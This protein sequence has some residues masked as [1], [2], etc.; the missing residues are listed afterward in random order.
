MYLRRRDEDIVRRESRIRK[1]PAAMSLSSTA[2]SLHVT[3]DKPSYAVT[4]QGVLILANNFPEKSCFYIYLKKSQSYN[5]KGFLHIT[6]LDYL[7]LFLFFWTNEKKPQTIMLGLD[8]TLMVT[9][10]EILNTSIQRHRD[11]V[12]FL[13]LPH[14]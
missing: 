12:T 3:S 4:S 14:S 2:K 11:L 6:K 7:S 8:I 10:L 5:F 1:I 9:H 13:G